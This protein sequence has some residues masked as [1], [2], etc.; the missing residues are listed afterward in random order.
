[1]TSAASPTSAASRP[2]GALFSANPLPLSPA[3]LAA[4]RAEIEAMA[5]ARHTVT[6]DEL[7]AAMTRVAAASSA[8]REALQTAE[9]ATP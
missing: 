4:I 6:A 2:I 9:A 5:A 1:M 8:F 7:D 3:K